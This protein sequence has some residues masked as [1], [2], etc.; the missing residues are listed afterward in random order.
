MN[1]ASF[2]KPDRRGGRRP[3]T[4]RRPAPKGEKLSPKSI[5]IHPDLWGRVEEI[6]S[7]E[8]RSRSEIAGVLIREAIEGREGKEE[9]EGRE[10]EEERV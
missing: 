1:R 8:G 2:K 4:G 7:K 5:S 9:K 3:K 10:E 6:A